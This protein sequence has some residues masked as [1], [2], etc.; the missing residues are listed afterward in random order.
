MEIFLQPTYLIPEL[1]DDAFVSGDLTDRAAAGP[2]L[3]C[4]K[5]RNEERLPHP[6]KEGPAYSQSPTG[7]G[8]GEAPRQIAEDDQNSLLGDG[9]GL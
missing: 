1:S 3:H 4:P 7:L 5:P 8:D 2:G 6:S 9:P